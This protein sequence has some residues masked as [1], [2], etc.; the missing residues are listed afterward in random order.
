MEG[1]AHCTRDGSSVFEADIKPFETKE[2]K[3]E[4]IGSE[5]LLFSFD[6]CGDVTPVGGHS[7]KLRGC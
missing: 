5:A 1:A 4:D 3:R 2:L 7:L 6:V